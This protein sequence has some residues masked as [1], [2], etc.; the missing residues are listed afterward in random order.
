MT[1]WPGSQRDGVG[2]GGWPGCD[3][4]RAA[5]RARRYG[6][7][8]KAP[9]RERSVA[10][11]AGPGS[12]GGG[13]LR[14]PVRPCPGPGRILVELGP[15]A[16]RRAV[17]LTRLTRL[18]NMAT[19]SCDSETTRTYFYRRIRFSIQ[20]RYLSQVPC[21]PQTARVLGVPATAFFP[22]T[23]RGGHRARRAPPMTRTM[24]RIIDS[25]NH[26]TI[27]IIRQ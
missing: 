26:H 25:D 27:I 19:Q 7:G 21:V 3:A 23:D 22:V 9:A 8:P 13:G 12:H 11:R 24:T 1:R 15:A 18:A 5:T 17:A 10:P 14:W 20:V 4:S 2:G 16:R 6:P